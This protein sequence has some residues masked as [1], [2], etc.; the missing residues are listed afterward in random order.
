[1]ENEETKQ[2]TNEEL[3][4]LKDYLELIDPQKKVFNNTHKIIELAANNEK[5]E[6]DIEKLYRSLD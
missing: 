6:E 1:M 5:R 4:Q 2:L 3:K